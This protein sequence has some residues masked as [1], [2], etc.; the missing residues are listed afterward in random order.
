MSPH[1]MHACR[2]ATARRQKAAVAPQAWAVVPM[3]VLCACSGGLLVGLWMISSMLQVDLHGL[4]RMALLS[5]RASEELGDALGP[6]WVE[7]FVVDI[8]RLGGRSVLGLAGLIAAGYL[9]AMKAWPSLSFLAISLLGGML[10]GDLMSS[11]RDPTS[12]R[13]SLRSPPRACR[14]GTQPL[15]PSPT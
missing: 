1:E 10:V 9:A 8:T 11:G 4:E 14:A 7:D 5:F 3:A 12:C 6:G 2:S 13:T 15:R